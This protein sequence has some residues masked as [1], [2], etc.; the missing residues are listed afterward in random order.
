M[1]LDIA[2]AGTTG[3][4][5]FAVL[6]YSPGNAWTPLNGPFTS[7]DMGEPIAPGETFY[8]ARISELEDT[9]FSVR[10]FGFKGPHMDV[11]I[12]WSYWTSKVVLD[13]Y[14]LTEDPLNGRFAATLRFQSAVPGS[15]VPLP[16]AALLGVLGLSFAGYRLR[17][18]A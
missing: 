16:G 17:R 4:W 10:A 12:Q 14:S 11:G 3:L 13:E 2:P 8:S 1:G 9:A 6:Y 5:D 18:M 7:F 15:V